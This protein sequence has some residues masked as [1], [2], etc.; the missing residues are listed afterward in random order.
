MMEIEDKIQMIGYQL[1]NLEFSYQNMLM[2]REK[3]F[4]NNFGNQMKSM[5]VQMLNMGIEIINLSMSFP[6][7]NDYLNINKQIKR[8]I[9]QIK[10]IDMR[11]NN[12]MGNAFGMGMN[13]N[14]M[15]NMGMG[16]NNNMMNDMGMGMNNNM[17][18]NIKQTIPKETKRIKF[19]ASSGS[20]ITIDTAYGTSLSE[21]AK[22]YFKELKKPE[23]INEVDKK[24]IFLYNGEKLSLKNN[25]KIEEI[26]KNIDF[27]IITVFDLNNLI[28]V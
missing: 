8:I 20:T 9:E 11:I 2:L 6:V 21:L 14:M 24:I 28:S 27:L 26:F 10:S 3:Q 1:K 12:P 19:D 23:L 13:N 15:N 4:L 5:G 18:N 22:K 17:I 16:M 7:M 25:T